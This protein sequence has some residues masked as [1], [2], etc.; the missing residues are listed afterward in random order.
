MHEV[1]KK[2][3]YSPVNVTAILQELN[4]FYADSGKNVTVGWVNVN[5]PFCHDPS[6]HLGINLLTNRCSCW[7]CGRRTSFW[8]YLK[9]KFGF[10]NYRLGKLFNQHSEMAQFGPETYQ[11]R[12]ER[13]F[14]Q[15]EL[16]WPSNVKDKPLPIHDKY[17]RKRGF[18]PQE[19]VPYYNLKFTGHNSRYTKNDRTQI[20]FRY[21]ILAPV[22][23]N[24]RA[25]NFI[26]RDVTETESAIRY[27]NCPNEEAIITTKDCLYNSDGVKDIAIFVEGP[28][29][30]WNIGFGSIGVI[31][32][33]VTKRQ[34]AYIQ[35]LRLKKAVLLF[36][37]G[38]KE[39]EDKL[40]DILSIFIPEVFSLE[41]LWDDYDDPG[42]L[43][44]Q[45][46]KEIKRLV[47]RR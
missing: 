23:M 36:D 22:I 27:K 20:D 17:L 10:D 25:V 43:T 2:K 26:G 34:I 45:Q 6:W 1:K 11:N 44:K 18:N 28:T 30:V 47:F 4:V 38:A 15:T 8:F 16:K 7:K 46:V 3:T 31:G 37:E 41:E 32:I 14:A 19:I 39:E 13:D 24:G 29:D 33:K 40:N 35:E 5:C 21:R 9:E 12:D 42:N